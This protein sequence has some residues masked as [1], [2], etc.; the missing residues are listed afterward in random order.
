MDKY[1]HQNVFE[2]RMPT[3][4]NSMQAQI[5]QLYDGT[6]KLEGCKKLLWHKIK[7]NEE[8]IQI[9]PKQKRH[10]P[11]APVVKVTNNN[12][13]NNKK[14]FSKRKKK[15]KR[16]K[17]SS[18]SS[19]LLLKAMAFIAVGFVLGQMYQKRQSSDKK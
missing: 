12:T 15:L 9:L 18:T 3:P 4:D 8:K 16:I 13:K 19:A 2:H 17:H 5:F 1:Y 6:L 10:F 11:F 7:I 14:Y